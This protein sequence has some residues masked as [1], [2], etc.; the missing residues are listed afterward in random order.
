MR[1]AP[2]NFAEDIPFLNLRWLAPSPKHLPDESNGA[3]AS[4]RGV[5]NED[6]VTGE[7]YGTDDSFKYTG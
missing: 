1:D 2:H 5:R 3:A 6:H 7:R 4:G